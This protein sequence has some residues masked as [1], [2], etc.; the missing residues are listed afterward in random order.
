MREPLGR[1]RPQCLLDGLIESWGGGMAAVVTSDKSQVGKSALLMH[2]V[3]IACGG[4]L[5]VIKATSDV[6]PAIAWSKA[7]PA[8]G[9]ILVVRRP[10]A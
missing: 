5:R 8:V 4:G 9:L 1:V 2:A 3:G 6:F 10:Y 7:S